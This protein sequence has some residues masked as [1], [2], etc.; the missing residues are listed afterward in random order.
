[1][2]IQ[3]LD[4]INKGPSN[5]KHKILVEA[6]YALIATSV[7]IWAIAYVQTRSVVE[8]EKPLEMVK[9]ESDGSLSDIQKE[10]FAKIMLEDL[11]NTPPLTEAKKEALAKS[12]MASINKNK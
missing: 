3:Y 11:K 1:M 5:K 8:E 6:L 9:S 2:V 10:N 7:I 4:T 12:M